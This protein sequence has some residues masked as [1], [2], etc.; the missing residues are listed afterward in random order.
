M[1]AIDQRPQSRREMGI[2]REGWLGFRFPDYGVLC[3]VSECVYQWQSQYSSSIPWL[4]YVES[5]LRSVN[6]G[7]AVHPPSRFAF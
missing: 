6:H 5:G 7:Q 2:E 4:E 3:V 1:L